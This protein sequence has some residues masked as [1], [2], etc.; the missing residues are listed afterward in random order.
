PTA[1][2]TLSLHDALPISLVGP[3]AGGAAQPPSA[4]HLDERNRIDIA[5]EPRPVARIVKYATS[6]LGV[7]LDPVLY[8]LEDGEGGIR[9]ANTADRK[10]T[11]L[12]SSHVKI[13]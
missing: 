7:D 6:V 11:R 10:S 12:N 4:F 8:L 2:S 5:L 13:S 9:V 1:V 3:I